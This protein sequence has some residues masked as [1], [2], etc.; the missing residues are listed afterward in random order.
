[1]LDNIENENQYHLRG[2]MPSMAK[3]HHALAQ[4]VDVIA[5]SQFKAAQRRVFRQLAEALLYEGIVQSVEHQVNGGRTEYMISGQNNQGTA[6]SYICE[7]ERKLSFGRIRLSEDSI[8]RREGNEETQAEDIAVFL[9]EIMALPGKPLAYLDS[10]L[11][12]MEQTLL[13]DAWSRYDRHLYPRLNQS[14]E[15]LTYDDLEGEVQEG[16]PYHPCFKSRIGFDLNDNALYGPEFHPRLKLIWIAVNREF[17]L[18]SS[19]ELMDHHAFIEQEIGEE[20][21]SQFRKILKRRGK[22]LVDFVFLPVHPWQWRKQIKALFHRYFTDGRMV[23]LGE[24]ADEYSPQ[25]SIRTLSNRTNSG[26]FNVKLSLGILNT[27]SVR[28]ILPRHTRN[29]PIVSGKL[30]KLLEQDAYLRD[31]LSF[32]MLKEIHGISFDYERLSSPIRTSGFGMLGALWRE[33]VCAYLKPGE[34]AAPYTAICHSNAEGTPFI[35]QWIARYGLQQWV[36][37]LLEV[38]LLP[39]IHLMYAHGVALEAHGQNLVLIHEQG[40]PKRLAARDFSGGVLLYNGINPD[41]SILPETSKHVE[42]RDVV[43][44]SLLFVNLAEVAFFLEKHYFCEEYS[45]WRMAA[46]TIYSYQQRFPG[47]KDSFGLYDL[48]EEFVEVGQ[49]ARRRLMGPDCERDHRIPNVLH[50]FSTK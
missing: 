27:S 11:H 48:F 47:L 5:S 49:L 36:R 35:A 29:G 24:G 17:A 9:Q 7:G 33:S 3:E 22:L 44:N 32:V 46:D 10:F 14:S 12:E 25:Q 30:G 31:E 23:L 43:H 6:V 34:E 20:T 2:G 21:F 41:P 28:T 50:A 4:V 13:K 18:L 1:M 26:K 15:S 39:L 19:S 8:Y 37:T 42:V 45:F 38:T 16:H 40:F